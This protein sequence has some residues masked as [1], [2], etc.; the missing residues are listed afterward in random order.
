MY[1]K[2]LLWLFSLSSNNNQYFLLTS[3]IS[4]M[5]KT[6]GPDFTVLYLKECYRL[7]TK[8]LAGKPETAVA[9]MRVATRRGLP[10]IVPGV[11]R[12]SIESGNILDIK[13]V[14]SLLSVFRVIKASPKLKT[15][16]ITDS[17]SGNSPVIGE[18]E[19]VSIFNKLK[20]SFGT[21]KIEKRNHLI[22]LT[23]AGPNSR[24]S[25]RGA[26]ADALAL[27]GS[28]VENAW[29]RLSAEFAPA[30]AALLEKEVVYASRWIEFLNQHS[31]IHI[32]RALT[33]Y[34][35]MFK[36][37][38]LSLKYEAAGKVRVFAITDI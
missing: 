9:P 25:I 1:T 37:G 23:T 11:L 20:R 30:L 24:I 5:Y 8:V 12:L 34:K 35:D 7:V 22:P 15:S 32:P 4:K 33:E 36:L 29:K 18:W 2:V 21:I 10:L 6:N 19:V 28:P 13:A 16:T 26:T 17:F 38:K 31:Y 3:H 27:V 14:S